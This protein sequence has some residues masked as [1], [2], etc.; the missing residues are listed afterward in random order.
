MEDGLLRLA[1][2]N[3]VQPDRFVSLATIKFIAGLQTQRSA[4]ASIDTRYN[5]KF[6]GG[7]PDALIAGQNVEISNHLTLQRRPGLLAYGVSNIPAPVFFFDWQLATTTDIILVIDTETQGGDNNAGPNGAV[8]N[9]SPTHSGIY[10]NKAQ[11]STQTQFMDVVNTLYLGDGEDLY[12]ITGP[13]LLTQ[14]NTFFAAGTGIPAFQNIVLPTQ[15][16]PWAS[17][18]LGFDS[19][20]SP[21]VV[22]SPN[23]TSNTGNQTSNTTSFSFQIGTS[24]TSGNLMI[25]AGAF[26]PTSGITP[27]IS[28]TSSNTW[29]K[30][31]DFTANSIQ[32]V[33]WSAIANAS[34]RP[35]ITVS[36]NS[37]VPVSGAG[38][39]EVSNMAGTV[40]VT[41]T[42]SG[43]SSTPQ[44][45]NV[46]TATANTLVFN[47]ASVNPLNTST[48]AAAPGW[49][50]PAVV[51]S[52]S[53]GG[54]NL[55]IG[56]EYITVSTPGVGVMSPWTEAG[57]ASLTPNQPDP[58]GGNSATQII[59]ASTSSTDSV[60]LEQS[61][62]PN[63]TPIASNTF[64]FSF[65]MKETGGP[66]TVSLE[67]EDQSGDIVSQAFALSTTWTKYQ[68]TG[69]MNS[70][71]NIIKVFLTDPTSTNT[72]DIYGAQLEIGG[73]A[74][75]TQ[76]TTTK[77]QGVWLWGILAPT[78]A[79]TF[80][81]QMAVGNT[82]APW[83]ANHLYHVGD[84]IV[85]SNGN[86]EYATNGGI[87][88][89]QDFPVTS[90]ASGTGVYT[91]TFS[92]SQYSGA[93]N[94]FAGLTVVIVGFT[95]A[96]NNG[97]FTVTASTL[98]TI[99][100][101]NSSSIAEAPGTA[102]A[103]FGVVGTTAGT[104][105]GSQPV[106]NKQVGGYTADGLQNIIV[107]T[108]TTPTPASGTTAS[109]TFG[110]NTTNGNVIMLVI[111]VSHP[112]VLAISD[113]Q[114]NTYVSGLS[115]GHGGHVPPGSGDSRTNSI[116]SGQFTM[117][118]YYALNITGGACTISVTGGGNTGTYL[119]AAELTDITSA[120]DSSFN[121]N[122]ATASG[123]S[124]FQTGGINNTNARDILLTVG[125]FAVSAS[126][127]SGAE[128]GSPPSGFNII[129]QDGP[130]GI[131]SN[132]ALLNI[133]TAF[134]SISA[135]TFYDPNWS[136][137]SP[138]TKSQVL[139]ITG[140][141]ESTVGTL[142]WLNQGQNGAGLTTTIGYQYYYS[143]GNS[144]TGHFSNVSPI[145]LSTGVIV[146][147]DVFVTGNT[148]P[149]IDPGSIIYTP[150]Q[151]QNRVPWQTDPQSDLIALYRNT[152]GGGFFYQDALF[153][154]GAAAQA[155]LIAA[156]YPGLT[157]T[158]V[159]YNGTMWTYEDTTPDVDLNT[160]IFAPIGLLNSLPPIGLKDLEYFS[161]RMWGSV[162]NILYYNTSADNATLLGVQQNGVPSESWEPTN[163]I[164]FN[165]FI[166]RIIA[167]GGGLLVMT[168]TDTW[169][170]TGQNLL[171]GG[172]NPQK[173]FAGHGL[174]DYN[175]ACLDGSSVWV[176]T[177]DRESLIINPNSGSVEF[178][179][180]IG[181]TL[182]NQF[183]PLN[184]YLARHIS[185]SQDNAVFMADNSTGWYRLN[186]NQQGA[187]MSGE[188]TPVWSPKADFTASIGGISAIG[189]IETVAGVH[190]L[191]VGSPALSISGVP[192]PGPVL[193]RDLT[194]FSD[195]G[196]PY[197]WTATIGSILLATSGKIAEAESITTEMNNIPTAT[198]IL[199]SVAAGTGVYTGTITGGAANAYAGMN[200]TIAG[201][202]NATNNG[203]F[204]I[205]ASTSTTLTT[206][207]L[208]T[209]AE[210]VAATAKLGAASQCTVLVLLEEIS[211]L[212]ET[213]TNSVNDP[214]QINPSSSVLA[215]RFYLAQ[216]AGVPMCKHLQ[217]QIS[218][219]TEITKDEM[220]AIT[221]RGAL[222]TEQA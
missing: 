61:V 69:T 204:L 4:F 34:T 207:N 169:F 2:A 103:K 118:L 101:S 110:A 117:Y 17:V 135:V 73:P 194:T 16:A 161:S 45:P 35:T 143:Y 125:A 71:S 27:S 177:S 134:E 119:A 93:N 221:V 91:G 13:N 62:T 166:T 130:V 53:S 107:Q 151:W 208:T 48:L 96:V 77:P 195:Y 183:D 49:T 9:Y 120:D 79:P 82:G 133:T 78:T 137:S 26:A 128:L 158:G 122:A 37:A 142:Q 92:N 191:L 88:P 32:N 148:R 75:T 72:M 187:S 199:T 66:I 90:V 30:Q 21:T 106:W 116:S 56:W 141:F 170:L 212:F 160:A 165:S 43:N 176:Y 81:T 95:R 149:M 220:L 197:P 188:Q 99:T 44:T 8:F 10:I 164:P 198:L 115:A 58:L 156:N 171:T 65:W 126:A 109:V 31:I 50:Q 60:Y 55:N 175:A 168:V 100:T 139:G 155:A 190:K 33:V 87:Y 14:S 24:M 42:G 39:F 46:V 214:P 193:V 40:S 5:S 83:Q 127:G 59:W 222:E 162:A 217:I 131:A 185:G 47:M 108:I 136:I 112:Q 145:S 219:G 196:V 19:T 12:K 74:T 159:T 210:T 157:T 146:G 173:S 25:V 111:Y 6:L 182:E 54:T 86:L 154:N 102:T 98:T 18:S 51:L 218:G 211:G 129:T 67:I 28:D 147:Q 213:L 70:T 85:D 152:D 84:T 203:V 138:T 23:G 29:T 179:F 124:T 209:I 192:I 180:A 15:S 114:S 184:T 163:F 63:Y 105:G 200:A 1:G 76:I 144:Y 22:Q 64:T 41:D 97:T 181:D 80:T 174:R 153:G 206:V 123:G 150:A 186:P 172:F 216:D 38:F 178:G 215:R 52:L 20:G 36:S 68:V 205:T 104:S 167:V 140:A 3:E 189:S 132:S 121:S 7:K 94:G 11:L 202:M 57:I 113:T 89:E 201:F